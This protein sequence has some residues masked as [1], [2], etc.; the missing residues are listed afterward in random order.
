MTAE[1]VVGILLTEEG[2]KDL[3]EALR[4]YS[5]QGPIGKYIYCHE[6]VPNGPYFT[7]IATPN[8]A[9]DTNFKVEISIPHRYVKLFVTAHEKR[10]IGFAEQP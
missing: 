3:G 4:P 9:T 7:F 5:S 8:N 2:W 6:V 1:N 10:H